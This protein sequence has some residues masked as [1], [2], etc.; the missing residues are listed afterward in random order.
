VVFQDVERLPV[1]V[2]VDRNRTMTK[3]GEHQGFAAAFTDHDLSARILGVIGKRLIFRV[4][5]I[6][7]RQRG[8]LCY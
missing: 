3:V 2:L 5:D 8:R 6:A 4:V 7:H 1:D